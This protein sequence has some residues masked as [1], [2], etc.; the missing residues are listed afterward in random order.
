MPVAAE[1]PVF[2]HWPGVECVGYILLLCAVVWMEECVV[3]GWLGTNTYTTL[4]TLQR[5]NTQL[6]PAMG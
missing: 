6:Y 5:N 3:G 2:G 4:H 1:G